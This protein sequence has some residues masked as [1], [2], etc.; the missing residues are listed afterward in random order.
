V[1][2]PRGI[3]SGILDVDIADIE[4]VK[5]NYTNSTITIFGKIYPLG[6]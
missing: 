3:E 1:L 2:L 6:N 4:D 5:I